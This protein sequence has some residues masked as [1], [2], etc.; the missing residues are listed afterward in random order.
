MKN[1][2]SFQF[3]M[4]NDQRVMEKQSLVFV[5]EIHRFLSVNDLSM[6]F[7]LSTA[8]Y[9]ITGPGRLGGWMDCRILQK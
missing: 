4:L 2:G 5:G 6:S 9:S 1:G 8:I 3:A 7:F